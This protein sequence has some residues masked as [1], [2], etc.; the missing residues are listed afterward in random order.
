[1][2]GSPRPVADSQPVISAFGRNFGGRRELGSEMTSIDAELLD[3]GLERLT[4]NSKSR[5][6]TRWTGDAAVAFAKRLLDQP[7]LT[8]GE[9]GDEVRL[10]DVPVG[11]N[12][13]GRID[14]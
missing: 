3:L 10:P 9:I 7:L 2:R 12:Q 4:R 11:A 8:L 1:M 13:P 6:S 5:G 14:P